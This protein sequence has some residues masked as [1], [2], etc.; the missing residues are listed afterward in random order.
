MENLERARAKVESDQRE[1][2]KLRRRDADS[3]FYPKLRKL[4]GA[5]FDSPFNFAWRMDF[6]GV[7]ADGN[8][9]F[10]L[11]VGNPPF[12]TARNPK[13]R[14][15]WRQRWP[16]VC[17]GTYQLVCPFFELGFG[18]LARSGELGYIVSNA[19]AKRNF[20][21]PL[22]ESF[23]VTVDVQKL[24]DCSGLMF[25]GHG[26]PT[27][28][29]FGRAKPPDPSEPIRVAAILPGGGDLSTP[30]EESPLWQTL[31]QHHDE[32][33]FSDSR[34]VIA[35]RLRADLAQWPWNFDSTALPILGVLHADAR[36]LAEFLDS[37]GSMFDTHKD[38][39][40][41]MSEA[42]AR[43]YGMELEGLAAYSIG[44]QVRNWPQ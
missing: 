15:L 42:L 1:L 44:D 39:V 22:I 37:F 20:G 19:F 32:P 27:C 26:T 8:G 30:P 4:E 40:F 33:G 35:D 29:V 10:D 2:E 34:V 3:Q 12:V 24:V 43:R 21:K 6:P 13:K 25:P 31:A 5:D 36:P 11:V 28:L 17:V 14:E 7:F 16:R 38:D 23:L 41:M 9:G 18:I